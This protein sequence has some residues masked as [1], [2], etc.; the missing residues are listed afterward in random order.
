[1]RGNKRSL[2]NTHTSKTRAEAPWQQNSAAGF[3]RCSLF[4]SLVFGGLENPFRQFPEEKMQMTHKH[5]K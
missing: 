5:M 3:P 1:M 4:N 2:F